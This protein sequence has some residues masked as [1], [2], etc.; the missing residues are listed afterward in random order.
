M[1]AAKQYKLKAEYLNGVSQNIYVPTSD[2]DTALTQISGLVGT[3]VTAMEEDST[4]T[5]VLS[6]SNIAYNDM[7]VQLSD[8]RGK[9][10]Y[11]NMLVKASVGL[12]QLKTAFVSKEIN[13]VSVANVAIMN[14]KVV[15]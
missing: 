12:P 11:L 3:K 6:S 15:A 8:N 9:K 2:L 4:A 5:T 1:A 13:G 7:T 14:E 10:T